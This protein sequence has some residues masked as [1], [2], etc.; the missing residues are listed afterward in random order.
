[1]AARKDALQLRTRAKTRLAY[2]RNLDEMGKQ[3]ASKIFVSKRMNPCY[4]VRRRF[5]CAAAEPVRR[6]RTSPARTYLFASLT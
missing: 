4:V 5:G 3:Q 2:Q 6:R 1:M